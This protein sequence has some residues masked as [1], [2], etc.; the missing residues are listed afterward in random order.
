MSEKTSFLKRKAFVQGWW[1]RKPPR[2]SPPLLL[3]LTLDFYECFSL[4]VFMTRPQSSSWVCIEHLLDS[5]PKDFWQNS[6]NF[7]WIQGTRMYC[8]SQSHG[9]DP[10]D[11]VDYS[12]LHTQNTHIAQL[13]C[14]NHRRKIDFLVLHRVK[15]IMFR[16]HSVRQDWTGEEI[17]MKNLNPTTTWTPWTRFSYKADTDSRSWAVK[18]L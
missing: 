4:C 1:R 16:Q 11:K 6:L 12:D 8:S 10:S 2:I 13:T 3:F 9:T 5:M 7:W 14:F 17:G 15:K 18:T